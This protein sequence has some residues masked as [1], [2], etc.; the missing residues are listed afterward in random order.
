MS[1]PHCKE[2]INGPISRY[3]FGLEIKQFNRFFNYRFQFIL[4]D[5]LRNCFYELYN[6]KIIKHNNV[7]YFIGTELQLVYNMNLYTRSCIPT[8]S[9]VATAIV[10]SLTAD[11]WRPITEQLYSSRGPN[12]VL[13]FIMMCQSGA[14]LAWI[15]YNS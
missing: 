5:K 11:E 14:L 9:S 12:A 13:R 3:F 4:G 15:E 2:H 8:T 6:G 1:I 10:P 7:I